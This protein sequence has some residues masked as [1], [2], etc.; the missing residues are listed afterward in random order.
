M[1]K[2]FA[3]LRDGRFE[4]K[5]EEIEPG[6]LIE[7]I[8]NRYDI[9]REQAAI[10]FVNNKHAKFEYQLREGDT[11]AIFPPIGGG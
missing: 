6:V 5:E 3:T 7:D 1:V 10:I 9:P 8:V 4:I 2:L 11:L